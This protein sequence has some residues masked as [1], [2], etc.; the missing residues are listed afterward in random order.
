MNFLLYTPN[1]LYIPWDL[2]KVY[3]ILRK[4]IADKSMNRHAQFKLRVL[5]TLKEVF[6]IFIYSLNV[7]PHNSLRV[8]S[9]LVYM[10]MKATLFQHYY[11]IF[12]HFGKILH[13]V[14]ILCCKITQSTVH[15]I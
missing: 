9:D 2:L 10:H 5:Y 15:I 8:F 1:F 14:Y 6:L 7:Q 3:N 4:G 13:N 11:N 12:Y